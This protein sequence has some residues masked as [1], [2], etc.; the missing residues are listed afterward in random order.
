MAHKHIDRRLGHSSYHTPND[1][2]LGYCKN[3]VHVGGM[4][5]SARQGMYLSEKQLLSN[6]Y[7][8]AEENEYYCAY[9]TTDGI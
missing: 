9:A 2:G 3:G 6:G 7:D 8:A 4:C 1:K 5:I